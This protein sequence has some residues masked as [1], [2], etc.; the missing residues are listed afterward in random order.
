[1]QTLCNYLLIANRL[2]DDRALEIHN[3]ATRAIDEWLLEKGVANPYE[4]K[5]IFNSL[6]PEGGGSFSRTQLQSG[7]A[8]LVEVH[9][10]ELS[11]SGQI[12]TTTVSLVKS[13]TKVLVYAAQSAHNVSVR[14]VPIVSDA[15]CPR[16]VRRLL[17]L[18]TCWELNGER[19]PSPVPTAYADE[20][21]GLELAKLIKASS[22]SLPILVVSENE[23]EL[24]W[25]KISE[26]L[27]YDLAGL[28]Y[29]VSISENA[30][31]SL[32]GSLGKINSCYM[33][34]VRLYWPNNNSSMEELSLRSTVWTASTLLSHDHDGKGA[35]RF[36]STVRRMIMSVAAVAV[37]PPQEIKQIYSYVAR[38]QLRELEEKAAANSEELKIAQLFFSENEQLRT[39]VEE[40]Q[41]EL[42]S[43][44]S[45]AQV[46]ESALSQNAKVPAESIDDIQP[47]CDVDSPPELGETRFY[48]KTHSTPNHDV[49][50]RVT[51]CSHSSWQDAS[52]AEKAKKG[53]IRLLG[54]DEWKSLHHC[55]KCK[56][57][58]MWRVRW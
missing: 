13:D 11:K 31:W 18:V 24:V 15:R 58:G 37:E 28:A 57:G 43:W 10:E 46:A 21:G 39:Q 50:V 54:N 44:S 7:N 19:L 51:N 40:L 22:R 5:G 38:K 26:Q 20:K 14:I 48:K 4:E 34:A 30:S 1:M 52:K 53:L 27:A 36:R 29:V 42:R 23:G 2:T 32:T 3:L 16:I 17:E 45:R 33:G 41:K 55:G 49:F 35:L 9:L 47:S 56:G 6:T 8:S 25:P 12:F